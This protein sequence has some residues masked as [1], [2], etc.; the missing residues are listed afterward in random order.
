LDFLGWLGSRIA[1]HLWMAVNIAIAFQP[2]C[3]LVYALCPPLLLMLLPWVVGR[4]TTFLAWSACVYLPALALVLWRFGR[5][6]LRVSFLEGAIVLPWLLVWLP[7]ASGETVRATAM[8]AAIAAARA[9]CHDASSLMTSLHE[10][11]EFSNAHAWMIVDGERY[12]WSYGE[13]R[14]VADSRPMASGGTCARFARRAW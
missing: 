9:E 4:F 8:H 1:A 13:M 6:L 3:A 2:L 12:I 14:F 10:W 11:D 7:L 5:R